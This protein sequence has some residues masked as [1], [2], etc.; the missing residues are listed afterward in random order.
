[1]ERGGPERAASLCV[2]DFRARLL[3]PVGLSRAGVGSLL[4]RRHRATTAS[5]AA[6]VTPSAVARIAV[7]PRAR[8]TTSP[9][10]LSTL[11]IALSALLHHTEIG[12]KGD[13]AS[14]VRAL[15]TAESRSVSPIATRA[16]AGEIVIVAGRAHGGGVA[17]RDTSRLHAV[18]R[19]IENAAR[20][21]TRTEM[22]T[23]GRPR[24]CT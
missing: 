20:A 7:V 3:S 1:M 6:P 22:L 9:V 2:R 23:Q 16:V 4:A 5:V 13:D 8:P 15:G 24:G 11:A 14:Q 10:R 21:A 12:V 19:A 18:V 17:G